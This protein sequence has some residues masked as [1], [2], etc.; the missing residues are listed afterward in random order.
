M[1]DRRRFCVSVRLTEG[2]LEELV[3][4]AGAKCLG[5]KLRN[6]ALYPARSRK[7]S[8]SEVPADVTRDLQG[9][10]E[11]LG[12]LAASKRDVSDA[13]LAELVDTLLLIS[14]RV[15]KDRK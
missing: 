3:A 6:L 1:K 11:N 14:E 7:R 15:R 10:L 5:T 8:K 4:K 13:T 12:Q 9:A 2:E